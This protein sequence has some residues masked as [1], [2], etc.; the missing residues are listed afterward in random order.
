MHTGHGQCQG[1][2]T[3]F[4]SH[5]AR[6][7]RGWR[8]RQSTRRRALKTRQSAGAAARRRGR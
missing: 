2:C 5:R 6:A 7:E 3:A 4:E 8:A 1:A